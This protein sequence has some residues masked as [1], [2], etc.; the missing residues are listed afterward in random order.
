MTLVVAI[1]PGP[2][3]GIATR[4]NNGTLYA[5]M[6]HNDLMSVWKY[7]EEAKPGVI[8]VER[9]MTGGRISNDG[10]YTVEA[11]GSIARC[12]W[13]LK[14]EFIWQRPAD[15]TPFIPQA[16]ELLGKTGNKKIESHEVDAVAHLI[17]WEYFRAQ[18]LRRLSLTGAGVAT[19]GVAVPDEQV[20]GGE[21][22]GE[23]SD[24]QVGDAAQ[25]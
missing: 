2:H 6:I 25:G 3:M 17:R 18:E 23:D 9:F 21:R 10:L 13:G 20:H 5:Q 14:A 4:L 15:R 1:D 24:A 22:A 8:I 12:A 11:Q 16:K 19:P 7:L